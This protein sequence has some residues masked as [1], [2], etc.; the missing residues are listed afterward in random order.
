VSAR[1]DLGIELRRRHDPVDETPF[2]R[3]RHVD[4]LAPEEH[5]E[6]AFPETLRET[7]TPGVAQKSP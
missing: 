6:C 5:L 2:H 3:R 7:G 4:E 1:R